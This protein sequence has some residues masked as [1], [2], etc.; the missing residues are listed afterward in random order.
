MASAPL[1]RSVKVFGN[2]YFYLHFRFFVFEAQFWYVL[3]F[4]VKINW[5]IQF[6]F[7]KASHEAIN[8]YY[9]ADKMCEKCS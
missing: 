9:H 7:Q 6:H 3:C 8:V 2:S 1:V 5:H 4:Y